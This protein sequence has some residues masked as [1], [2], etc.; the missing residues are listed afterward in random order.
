MANNTFISQA[1]DI[2]KQAIEADTKGEY[3]NAL[4]L[5]KKSLGKEGR[6]RQGARKGGGRAIL[7]KFSGPAVRCHG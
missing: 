4:G 6:G 3:E 7:A 1:I 2:V 5:Y